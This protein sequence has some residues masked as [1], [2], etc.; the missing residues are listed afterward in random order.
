MYFA[1]LKLFFGKK[2]ILKNIPEIFEIIFKKNI[3]KIISKIY[4]F[5]IN[6]FLKKKLFN[7][8]MIHRK[9]ECP[10]KIRNVKVSRI[11]LCLSQ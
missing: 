2:N 3:Y 10:Q 4:N 7:P 5:G 9:P 6:L 1:Y 11:S 8:Q